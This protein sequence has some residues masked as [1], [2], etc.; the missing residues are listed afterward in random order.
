M[1]QFCMDMQDQ[2][3]NRPG[4]LTLRFDSTPNNYADLKSHQ[5]SR[6]YPVLKRSGSSERDKV[7]AQ[8]QADCSNNPMTPTTFLNPKDVPADSEQFAE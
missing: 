6:N 4:S 8:L 3:P 5:H 2:S 1:S 7:I